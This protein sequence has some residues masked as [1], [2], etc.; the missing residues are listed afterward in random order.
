MS[1][2]ENASNE[3]A[4]ILAAVADYYDAALA[5]HGPTARGVDWK[6]DASHRLRHAQF[7]RD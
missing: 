6:D 4:S 7:L 1:G 2:P 5:R 3:H